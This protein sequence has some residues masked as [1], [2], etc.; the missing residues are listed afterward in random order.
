MS[1]SW[2]RLLEAAP[3]RIGGADVIVFTPIDERHRFTGGCR[4]VVAGVAGWP[5][6]GLAIC[7]YEGEDSVYLFGCDER[8]SGVTDTWHPTVEDAMR[9][10][11]FEYE[12]VTA[13]WQQQAGHE[14]LHLQA[15]FGRSAC[16]M[17]DPPRRAR[18]QPAVTGDEHTVVRRSNG[19]EYVQIPAGSATSAG[20]SR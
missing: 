18:R 10:A 14:G 7:R 19:Q 16:S 17:A 12:G 9:Q 6:A 4:Q 8:W 15:F 5:A 3:R 11:E 2:G 1:A 13:T 20:P